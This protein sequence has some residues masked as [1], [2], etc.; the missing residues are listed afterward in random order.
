MN[1][2]IIFS[3]VALI[4]S[5]FSLLFFSIYPSIKKYLIKKSL[6]LIIKFY[7][8]YSILNPYLINSY[9]WKNILTN[10]LI[11]Q[12]IFAYGFP[13]FIFIFNNTKGEFNPFSFELTYLFET[14]T[15]KEIKDFFSF[16]R[17]TWKKLQKIK[18][19][20]NT[21][22][23]I[24]K[25]KNSNT[26]IYRDN[27]ESNINTSISM[28]PNFDTL[29][30]YTFSIET[31]GWNEEKLNLDKI[32]CD[33]RKK[34]INE[35]KSSHFSINIRFQNSFELNN[36][37]FD[38]SYSLVFKNW[39]INKIETF[40]EK[41]S[42]LLDDIDQK[43]FENQKKW[44]NKTFKINFDDFWEYKEKYNTYKSFQKIEENV[45]NLKQ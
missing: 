8:L 9:D 22:E 16:W 38:Y 29:K 2:S 1:F 45:K 26:I 19:V 15:I 39:K 7:D 37:K 42:V 5:I 44:I 23:Y 34:F 28:C 43:K 24:Y 11:Q 4:I 12:K 40:I 10:K 21:F 31:S 20:I 18:N 14:L 27:F 33:K 32:I 30:M 3:I 13:R 6:N 35:L 36:K 41:C 17:L 25:E